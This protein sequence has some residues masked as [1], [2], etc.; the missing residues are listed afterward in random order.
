MISINIWYRK[1]TLKRNSWERPEKKEER[2]QKKWVIY[3]RRQS[4]TKNKKMPKWRQIFLS[5]RFPLFIEFFC[6]KRYD[7]L[8][9]K[10]YGMAK[11]P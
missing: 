2:K 5:E 3:R 9:R 4:S 10:I 1:E 6:F 11:K 8:P 7:R